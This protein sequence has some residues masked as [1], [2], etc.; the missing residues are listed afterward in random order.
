MPDGGRLTIET[1]NCEL[2][3]ACALWSR[4]MQPGPYVCIAVTDTGIG[5]S[6]ETIE[7]AFEPFFTTKPIGQGTGLGLSMI[8]GFVRQSGGYVDICSEVGLGTTVNLYLPRHDGVADRVA[9]RGAASM[10]ALRAHGE[11]VLVVD[12]EPGVRLLIAEV[13][14]DVGYSV[15]QAVDGVSAMKILESPA[16]IDLLI[17]DVGL[18]GGLNGRQVADAARAIRPGLKV[19]LVTGYA[20]A[21]ALGADPLGQGIEVLTKPFEID[22]LA[23]RVYAIIERQDHAERDDSSGV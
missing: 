23:G 20:E 15:I 1:R 10:A 4:D 18:P 22:V 19:L 13:L 5:M 14:R 11:T 12:D 6:E 16:H 7:K 8:Y 3:E 2:D 17:S 21:S 9:A